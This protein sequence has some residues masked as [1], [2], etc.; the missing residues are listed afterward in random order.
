ML[1][2]QTFENNIYMKLFRWLYILLMGNLCLLGVNLPFFVAAICLAIDI[3]NLPLFIFS[4]FFIGP[5]FIT[6]F[7]LL[8]RFKEEKEI[9]PVLVFMKEF[10]QFWLRGIIY[11]FI[12]WFGTILAVTD[13]L[14]FTQWSVGYWMISFFIL[15][16]G[17]CLA[18]SINCWYFQV[19][20]PKAKKRDILRIAIYYTLRKWYISALNVLLFLLIFIVMLLKPA[21]GF[22]ITPILFMG[23]IYLNVK[24]QANLKNKDKN[25]KI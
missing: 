20:N 18:S 11:W 6:L 24:K 5:G 22:M 4:L 16:T 8:D 15:L 2:K 10:H 12:G 13:G 25:K 19:R 9:E 7:A 23:L 3:R 14:F 17:M 21:I 1:S